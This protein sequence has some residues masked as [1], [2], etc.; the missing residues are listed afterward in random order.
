MHF[1]ITYENGEKL[2]YKVKPRHLVA[3][4]DSYPEGLGENFK[5]ISQLAHIASGDPRPYQE[6]LE[7]VDELE[8][9][10]PE[11]ATPNGGA[12]ARKGKAVPT[13]TP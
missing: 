2:T 8:A 1:D 9:Q 5:A 7:D 3:F 13:R 6:W 11:Q 10:Q 12:P 4:E